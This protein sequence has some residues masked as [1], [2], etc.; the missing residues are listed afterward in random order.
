M[1]VQYLI[2]LFRKILHAAE[3]KAGVGAVLSILTFFFD[4]L[5]IISIVAI[6][7]L[8]IIDFFFGIGAARATGDAINSSKLRRTAIK[9]VVYFS[10]IATA[11]ITEYT[12]PLGFLDETVIG[13]LAATEMMSVL[14]NAGRM[15]YPVPQSLLKILGDFI[16]SKNNKK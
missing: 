8:I 10:L 11:R 6:F 1:D 2:H 4:P 13:F 16:T 7:M 9:L 5:H 15:G 3:F 12:L 14:E